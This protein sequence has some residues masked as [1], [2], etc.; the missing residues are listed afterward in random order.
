MEENIKIFTK[1][2]I[3]I[4]KTAALIISRKGIQNLTIKNLSKK[5][6]ITE[7][8]IY[9]HFKNKEEIL[10][11]I[12]L[13]FKQ[14]I[15]EDFIYSKTDTNKSKEVISILEKFLHELLKIFLQYP[16]FSFILFSEEIFQNNKRIFNQI[17]RLMK[18][19]ETRILKLITS[20]IKFKEIRTDISAENITHIILGSIRLLIKKWYF[21]NFKND[22]NKEFNS[23]W[24]SLKKLILTK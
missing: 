6:G 16:A 3:E 2:Q 10:S 21:S 20:A 24:K 1:R 11:N 14:K 13:Y 7:P 4:I 18:D 17:M 22:L 5:I 23:L 8:A 12:L 15:D 9:R 19:E